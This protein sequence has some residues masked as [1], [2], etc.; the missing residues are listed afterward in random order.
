VD[1]VFFGNL[2]ANPAFELDTNADNRPDGWTTNAHV[3]RSNAARKSGSFAMRHT[4]TDNSSYTI[5][6][7]V[8]GLAAGSTYTFS[9][10]V[11]IPATTDTFEFRLEVQWRNASNALIGT[12]PIKSFTTHTNGA[13]TAANA[14]VQAPAGATSGTVAMVVSSLNA[15]VDVDDLAL[16][17]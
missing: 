1:D 13:W 2:L 7:K 12:S 9:G 6:Q 17:P 15:T 14:S 5:S 4:A 8:T 3:T 10:Y 11:R 16:W